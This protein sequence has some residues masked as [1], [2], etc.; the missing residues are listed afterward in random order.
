MEDMNQQNVHVFVSDQRHNVSLFQDLEQDDCGKTSLSDAK[1]E[2]K[3]SSGQF[4][5]F[6][7]HAK[8]LNI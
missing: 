1:T 4:C 8:F 5:R 7:I 2:T 3:A 6:N